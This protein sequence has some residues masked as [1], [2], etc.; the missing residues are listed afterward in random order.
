[1]VTRDETPVRKSSAG[2][3][4]DET[5]HGNSCKSPWG[6][7]SPQGLAWAVG[8]ASVTAASSVPGGP[9]RCG[10]ANSCPSGCRVLRGQHAGGVQ[11]YKD[12]LKSANVTKG[13]QDPHPSP[14]PALNPS[15]WAHGEQK[16]PGTLLPALP[17]PGHWTLGEP[18]KLLGTLFPHLRHRTQSA[19]PTP[20]G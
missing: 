17:F 9:L 6:S 5:K 16:G 15:P 1:M 18:A 12:T 19:L 13:S 2:R 10:L 7:W 4:R 11:C 14:T 3:H 20:Q 8:S